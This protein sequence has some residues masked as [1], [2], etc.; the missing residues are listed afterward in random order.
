MSE[1]GERWCSPT[2]GTGGAQPAWRP[3]PEPGCA[4]AA[5]PRPPPG[6]LLPR[7]GLLPPQPE[8]TRYK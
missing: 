7:P 3:R 8:T 6:P 5:P 2:V 1:H 4:G